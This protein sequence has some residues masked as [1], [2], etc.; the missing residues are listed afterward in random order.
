M[1]APRRQG[2]AARAA[3]ALAGVVTLAALF[4][5]A[6]GQLA[7]WQQYVSGRNRLRATLPILACAR[8]AL[9]AAG[10]RWARARALL[11]H[12]SHFPRRRA[13]GC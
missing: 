12:A 13:A 1:A 7:P 3:L 6:E 10:R 9:L 8:L 11:A 5:Q 4:G 2:R